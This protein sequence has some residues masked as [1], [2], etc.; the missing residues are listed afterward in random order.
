MG[1]FEARDLARQLERTIQETREIQSRI[2]QGCRELNGALR[3]V[4]SATA[5][6]RVGIH[7]P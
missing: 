6:A 1:Q 2:L 7:T 4:F 3:K 5:E